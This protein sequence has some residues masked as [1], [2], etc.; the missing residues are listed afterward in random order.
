MGDTAQRIK[1][2]TVPL[3]MCPASN[4]ATKGLEP[5]QHPFGLLYPAG[6]N[7]TLNTHN[8]VMSNTSMTKEYQFATEHGGLNPSDLIDI[9]RGSLQA[10]FCSETTKERLWATAIAPGF[11]EVGLPATTT[12]SP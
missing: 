12:W 2:E 10:A 3:E 1:S 6:F 11:L 5:D 4:L 8:R 9:A 7:V